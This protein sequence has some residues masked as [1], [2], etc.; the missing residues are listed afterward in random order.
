MDKQEIIEESRRINTFDISII[1]DEDCCTLFVPKH[2]ATRTSPDEMVYL[3]S[4]LS[5]DDIVEEAIEAIEVIELTY[6]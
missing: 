1:P 6:N 3:E 4:K 5:V 2:P